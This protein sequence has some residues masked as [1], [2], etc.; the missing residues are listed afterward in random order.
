MKDDELQKHLTYITNKKLTNLHSTK[1]KGVTAIW[2][3]DTAY[4]SFYFDEEPTES[5]R[6]DIADICTEIIAQMPKGMLEDKYLMVNNSYQ[7]PKKFLAYEK[8]KSYH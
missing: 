7:L 4:L 5:E 6:E 1:I 3:H 8:D 2:E